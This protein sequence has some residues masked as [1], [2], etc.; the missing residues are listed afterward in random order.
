MAPFTDGGRRAGPDELGDH[1]HFLLLRLAA[2]SRWRSISRCATARLARSR[3]TTSCARCGVCTASQAG[4]ARVR[5]SALHAGGRRGAAGGGQRRRRV[6]ARLLRALYRGS[7]GGRLREAAGAGG[8]ASFADV[9]PAARGGAT[10]RLDSGA[11]RA[12]REPSRLRTRRCTWPGSIL[13][14]EISRDRWTASPVASGC[15]DGARAVTGRATPSRWPSS[16]ERASRRPRVSRS[17][18]I[19]SSTSSRSKR[20]A[21]CSPPTRRRFREW[22]A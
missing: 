22:L 11:A 13:T 1:L 9:T 20:P 15:R 2:P 16:I 10:S 3:S 5:R 12:R 7:R 4:G 21:A 19:R 17:A 14:I 18:K 6:C 8:A